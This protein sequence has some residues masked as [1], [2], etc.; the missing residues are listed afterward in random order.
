MSDDLIEMLKAEFA[1]HEKRQRAAECKQWCAELDDTPPDAKL[2]LKDGLKA[3]I[4][5]QPLRWLSTGFENAASGLA[6][7]Y[8]LIRHPIVSPRSFKSSNGLLPW[9]LL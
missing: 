2:V 9:T 8:P 5:L 3:D 6:V 7:A 1:K 4:E